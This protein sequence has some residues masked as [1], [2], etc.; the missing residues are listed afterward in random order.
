V[1]SYIPGYASALIR[2]LYIMRAGINYEHTMT[3]DDGITPTAGRSPE[4]PPSAPPVLHSADLQRPPHPGDVES[5][6]S[7]PWT[8]T[9]AVAGHAPDFALMS[10]DL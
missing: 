9:G 1:V 4:W 5:G 8:G 3:N 10:D 7:H 2:I 6:P